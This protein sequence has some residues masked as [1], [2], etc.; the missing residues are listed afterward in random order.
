MT[1]PKYPIDQLR[2]SG[3]ATLS[4]VILMLGLLAY[5]I[6]APV[7]FAKKSKVV[8]CHM[9]TGNPENSHTIKVS[10]NALQA[11]LD[12]GDSIGEC[13]TNETGGG[14]S[15]ETQAQID[16]IQDKINDPDFGLFE[17]K[18]EIIELL[19]AVAV[20]QATVDNIQAP[21]SSHHVPFEALVTTHSICDHPG[22]GPSVGQVRITGTAHTGDYIV[23]G[24]FMNPNGAN[25]VNDSDS[26]KLRALSVDGLT[27]GFTQSGN[28]IGNTNGSSA[29][30][31]M[32]QPLN[33]GGNFPHQLAVRSGTQIHDVLIEITCDAGT[34]GGSLG[35]F[36]NQIRVSG[37]KHVDDE[38]VVDF[39]GPIP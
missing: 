28:L 26:I 19:D 1:T 17:I 21:G 6:T 2:S 38:I 8:I 33:D 25:G 13:Q 34:T 10:E 24:V 39:L 32:G 12:H 3:V 14:I 5:S 35:F 4:A 7:A 27:G 22:S 16:D 30:D 9:P 15:P 29:F 18:A 11:H 23:T 20:L 36:A 37:W 31:L